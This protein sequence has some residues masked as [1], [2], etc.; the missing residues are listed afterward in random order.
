MGC[1]PTLR[2]HFSPLNPDQKNDDGNGG[3]GGG[4][5]SGGD[6]GGGNGGPTNQVAFGQITQDQ[7]NVIQGY[8]FDPDHPT[9]SVRIEVSFDGAIQEIITT[10]EP[11]ANVQRYGHTI[12][13]PFGFS[14]PKPSSGEYSFVTFKVFDKDTGEKIPLYGSPVAL[15]PNSNGSLGEYTVENLSSY[16]IHSQYNF[17]LLFSEQDAPTL[18]EIQ[19]MKIEINGEVV[20]GL[21]PVKESL[22]NPGRY[23]IVGARKTLHLPPNFRDKAIVSE[24]T[25][26]MHQQFS[27]GANARSWMDQDN[28]ANQNRSRFIVYAQNSSTPYIWIPQNE[29]YT[30]LIGQPNTATQSFERIGR[31]YP[32]GNENLPPLRALLGR[33]IVTLP[34]E[35]NHGRLEIQLGNVIL[36]EPEE[37]VTL[38]RFVME[39]GNDFLFRLR[40][41]ELYRVNASPS[42]TNGR[43]RHTLW[44]LSKCS[45]G[46]I[47]DGSFVSWPGHFALTSQQGSQDFQTIEALSEIVP[48]ALPSY[49][50]AK[51]TKAFGSIGYFPNLPGNFSESTFR[52]R[53]LT[54]RQCTFDDVFSFYHPNGQGGKYL[55]PY[56]HIGGADLNKS[57][58]GGAQEEFNA[59]GLQ[60]S[61]IL[62]LAGQTTCAYPKIFASLSRQWVRNIFY[63]TKEQTG[64]YAMIDFSGRLEDAP[65]YISRFSPYCSAYT[66]DNVLVDFL[67]YRGSSSNGCP[68]DFS[69]NPAKNI[70]QIRA[71]DNEHWVYNGVSNRFELTGDESDS[72]F[73][74]WVGK[75]G[76]QEWLHDF[77]PNLPIY[78]L[79]RLSNNNRAAGRFTKNILRILAFTGGTAIHQELI[80]GIQ[81]KIT[82]LLSVINQNLNQYGTQLPIEDR[83]MSFYVAEG[84]A[85]AITNP[86]LHGRNDIAVTWTMGFTG[87][88]ITNLLNSRFS[89][90]EVRRLGQIMMN[91]MPHFNKRLSDGR[92]IS[93]GFIAMNDPFNLFD[94]P[95]LQAQEPW[96]MGIISV[97][98][99]PQYQNHHNQSYFRNYVI[100]HYH[101]WFQNN[102]ARDYFWTLSKWISWITNPEVDP[103]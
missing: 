100:P 77:G 96:V 42:V 56:N 103:N 70:T 43:E 62:S 19:A 81:R 95:Y 88:L 86:S 25:Q 73:F 21:I 80:S 16:P 38:D 5:G 15:N 33:M 9:T 26:T 48:M 69:T 37:S 83:A 34:R 39:T 55:A 72:T 89:N 57:S 32:N 8:A 90:N 49:A 59:T 82:K 40:T 1:Q 45:D 7:G 4:G 13:G 94:P 99:H 79:N 18:S 71:H 44:D 65:L 17:P 2:S 101:N 64:S 47:P 3:S 87:E 67:K 10:N 23:R 61:L 20:D 92:V 6:G 54:S 28:I 60:E 68:N 66:Q 14:F 30:R 41:P 74:E 58:A 11:I 75:I 93:P 76:Y 91:A 50:K 63:F 85:G 31:F 12:N 98:L 51:R 52:S 97:G 36:E 35:A 53:M 27:Y 22:K 102:G 84:R 29:R 78:G 24:S 46:L